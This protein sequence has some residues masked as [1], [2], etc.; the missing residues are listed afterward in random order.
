SMVAERQ[1]NWQGGWFQLLLLSSFRLA[2]VVAPTRPIMCQFSLFFY[3]PLESVSPAVDINP[4]WLILSLSCS[5]PTDSRPIQSTFFY[6]PPGVVSTTSNISGTAD[7]AL[8]NS[9]AA[10]T[11]NINLHEYEYGWGCPTTLIGI[12]KKY[13]Q[14]GKKLKLNNTSSFIV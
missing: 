4:D 9:L 14:S 1:Q 2:T 12:P 7:H 11:G 6:L 10:W 8:W 13:T 3:L 5:N